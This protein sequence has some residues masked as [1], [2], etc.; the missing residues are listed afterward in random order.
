MAAI[1][2]VREFLEGAWEAA[3]LW[4][5]FIPPLPYS[6]M[7]FLNRVKQGTGTTH[8]RVQKWLTASNWWNVYASS[9]TV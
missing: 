2:S 5:Y 9:I 6:C 4:T 1:N 8:V 3:C 7:A